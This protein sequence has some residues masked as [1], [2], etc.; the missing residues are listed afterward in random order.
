MPDAHDVDRSVDRSQNLASEQIA[1]SAAGRSA[2]DARRHTGTTSLIGVATILVVA[3]NL[4]LPGLH[5]PVAMSIALT[6]VGYALARA[7]HRSTSS[8]RWKLPLLLGL[9]ARA[10]PSVLLVVSLT[11]LYGLVTTGGLAPSQTRAL[12][13]GLTFTSNI[14]PF[15]TEAR[16][17]PVGHLWAVALVGQTAIVAP[18]LLTAGARR[19]DRRHRAYVLMAVAAVLAAVR[20]V[21]LLG[22]EN[23]SWLAP[24]AAGLIGFSAVWTSLDGLLVGLAVGTIPLASLHRHPTTKIVVPTLLLLAALLAVPAVGPAAVTVG[25]RVPLAAALTGMVLASAAIFSLP[26]RVDQVLADAWLDR[27]GTRSF[28]LYLWHIPFAYGISSADPFHW[29]GLVVFVVTVTISLAAATITY[30]SIELP[31]QATLQWFG[32]RW[33]P[34]GLPVLNVPAPQRDKWRRWDE[35]SLDNLPRP[36]RRRNSS[37]SAGRLWQ[38]GD[39]NDRNAGSGKDTFGPGEGSAIAS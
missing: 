30:R 36:V 23:S 6:I 20:G 35:I 16:F 22:V 19:I 25:V 5:Q 29:H 4:G 39:R 12:L 21:T 17:L 3:A 1:T 27:I 2:P 7:V 14:V 10:L 9:A 33:L 24:P 11:G 32:R 13:A 34:S 26:S 18:L 8:E 38:H 37:V 31:A 28:T 15:V